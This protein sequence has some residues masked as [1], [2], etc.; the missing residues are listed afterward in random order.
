MTAHFQKNLFFTGEEDSV[1][2]RIARIW[3]PSHLGRGRMYLLLSVWHGMV[4]VH[5]VVGPVGGQAV[6]GDVFHF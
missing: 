3:I 4:Y 6:L 5:V 2:H 1:I